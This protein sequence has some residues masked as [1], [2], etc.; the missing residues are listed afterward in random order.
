L[1]KLEEKRIEMGKPALVLGIGNLLMGDEGLGIQAVEYL[2]R[3]PWPD[4]I[5]FVDGGTGGFHLL[6]LFDEFDP[7]IIIDACMD[8]RP[9]GSIQVFHPRFGA[10]FPPSLS[11]HEIGLRDLLEAALLLEVSLDVHLVAVTIGSMDALTVELSPIARAALPGIAAAVR[12]LLQSQ[13]F[14]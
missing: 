6:G 5:N 13:S 9:P 14:S 12:D 7:V 2:K 4:Q 10:D 11:M 3:L 1:Q 8:E